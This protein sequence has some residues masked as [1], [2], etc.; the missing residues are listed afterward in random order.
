[1]NIKPILLSV[2]GGGVEAVVLAVMRCCIVSSDG[3]SPYD[4]CLGSG[5]TSPLFLI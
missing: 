4:G 3:L 2:I 1:M 5:V